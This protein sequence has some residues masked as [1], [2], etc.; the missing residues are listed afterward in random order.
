MLGSRH[1]KTR[2]GLSLLVDVLEQA[3]SAILV[4]D[5]NIGV[6]V[7]GLAFDHRYLTLCRSKHLGEL[8]GTGVYWSGFATEES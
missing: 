4:R 6:E 8:M 5:V 2:C 3:F 1:V 7:L